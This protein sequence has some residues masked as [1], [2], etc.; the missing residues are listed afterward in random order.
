[1]QANFSAKTVAKVMR[2]GKQEHLC[3]RPI[4]LGWSREMVTSIYAMAMGF[5]NSWANL[6]DTAT[7]SSPKFPN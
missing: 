2:A 7:P 1:M 4:M 3:Y 5:P 6:T